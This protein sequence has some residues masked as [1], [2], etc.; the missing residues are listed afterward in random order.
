V[1]LPTISVVIASRNRPEALRLSLPLYLG[2]G[3][4]PRELV[5]VGA[6][7]GPAPARAAVDALAAAASFPVRFMTAE[8]R[9]AGQRNAGAETCDGEVL[10]FPDDDSLLFPDT[11]EELARVYAMDEG[12]ALAGVSCENSLASPYDDAE[13]AAA[14]RRAAFEAD[15]PSPLRRLSHH[16]DSTYL[17]TPLAVL[18][19]AL[20][21]EGRLPDRL[22]AAGCRLRS[23][24]YGFLMSFRAE[25]FRRTPF[26]ANL[27][28]Y[29]WGEDRDIC[30]A[31]YGPAVFA[32]APKAR[33]YHHRF[34]GRRA[35][36]FWFGKALILNHVYILCR[37]AP[38]GHRAR[39][40]VW[41]FFAWETTK[42][43]VRLVWLWDRDQHRRGHGTLVG[44]RGALGLLDAPRDDLD[45]VYA[46]LM[47]RGETP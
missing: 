5:V 30:F 17:R 38:P 41:R 11:L 7:D 39:A 34:P 18:D 13:D 35:E 21:A 10:F 46:A 12:G 27:K 32:V 9:A 23:W 3:H 20:V 43:L 19:D 40:R 2:Q 16:I 15:R 28:K 1:P 33:V 45:R 37:H 42:S 4:P 29:S 24:Q 6:R 36:G 31:M 25:A 47:A 8:A 14:A 44:I 22:A 26:N